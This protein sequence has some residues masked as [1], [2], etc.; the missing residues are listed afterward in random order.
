MRIFGFD[1]GSQ[2]AG[3]AIVEGE[4]T[5]WRHVDNGVIRPKTTLPYLDRLAQIYE[6][7]TQLLREFAPD[8]FAIEE[9]FLAHNV[10]S[11]LQL[12]QAR[13]VALLAA[14]QAKLPIHAYSAR[15]VKQSV[16][17]NGNAT[18]EQIQFMTSKLLKLPEPAAADA[19]DA[20]A[21]ALTHGYHVRSAHGA[22]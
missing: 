22:R 2:C 10:K 9:V 17:G 14:H 20:L 15:V 21:I 19:A 11:A 1:P 4:R 18:K 12:G 3:Y 6:R 16:V 8:A 7:L 5:T 13:G